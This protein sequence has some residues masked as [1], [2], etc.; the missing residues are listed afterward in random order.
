MTLLG[1][2]ASHEQYPPSEL[3]DYVRAADAAG[4][5]GVLCADHFHPWLE[6]NGHSGFAWSWLGAALQATPM[7]FGVV[8]APGDRYHPAIIAQAAPTLAEMFRDRFWIAVGS[9]EAL[10][11]PL[12]VRVER[13]DGY[14]SSGNRSG[15]I[16]RSSR[17]GATPHRRKRP[18]PPARSSERDVH[19]FAAATAL[20]AA[21]RTC[22]A[23][24][25]AWLLPGAPRRAIASN[26]A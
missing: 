26:R 14:S 19:P 15:T 22:T 20:F 17:D 21:R 5:E 6:A 16:S 18:I 24:C 11:E 2:H 3:L 13:Q 7:S 25:A 4:F 1:Y 10:N 23:S 9:G 8:N 12:P